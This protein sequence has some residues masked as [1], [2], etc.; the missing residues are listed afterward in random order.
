[1]NLTTQDLELI[2]Q[3][4]RAAVAEATSELVTKA[5]FRAFREDVRLAQTQFYPREMI[6]LFRKQAIEDRDRLWVALKEMQV[7]LDTQGNLL[8]N[9]WSTT[10]GKVALVAGVALQLYELWSLFH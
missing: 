10:A 5:E 8:A 7:R 9:L 1:V 2:K 3:T 4:V 6:D